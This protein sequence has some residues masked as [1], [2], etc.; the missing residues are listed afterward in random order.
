[1]DNRNWNTKLVS[2]RYKYLVQKVTD[3][4]APPPAPA[5]TNAAV[6]QPKGK[7]KSDSAAKSKSTASTSARQTKLLEA[8]AEPRKELRL[9]PKPGDKQTTVM[10]INLTVD[11]TIGEMPSQTIKL[12]TITIASEATV[13][14]VSDQGDITFELAISKADFAAEPGTMPQIVEPLKAA[15]ASLKGLSG[16]GTASSRGLSKGMDFKL[17]ADAAPQTR[18]LIEQM[19]E[20]F[21]NLVVPLPAEPVGAGAKWEARMPFKS[22]GA[23]ITQTA[24]YEL[25]S[26]EDERLVVKSTIA[27]SAANQTIQNAALPGLKLNLT[28]MTG[29]GTGSTSL[30]L[31]QLLAS[32]RTLELHTEQAVTMDAGG[33]PQPLTVATDLKLRSEAK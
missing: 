33:Q 10:S 19:K 9:H 25:A 6:E 28:K 18:Q 7:T 16:T 1:M 2:Y 8:G 4:S 23:T 31:T 13:K 27:Q 12:P 20:A 24:T 11:T 29:K 5:K 26:L 21:D 30:S 15:L 32:E 17:P 14:G 3:L 22:Q